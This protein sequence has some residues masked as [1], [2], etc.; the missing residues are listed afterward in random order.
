MKITVHRKGM[1]AAAQLAL[2]SA[3]DGKIKPILACAK[4]TA[5]PEGICLIEA[6]DTEVGVT[7][8]VRGVKVEQSGEMLLP[9]ALLASILREANEDELTLE[10]C[11]R[12][13]VIEGTTSRFELPPGNVQDFPASPEFDHGPHH[14]LTAGELKEMIRRINFAT[15][16]I[17]HV[18]MGPTVRGVLFDLTEDRTSLITSD[19]HVAAIAEGKGRAVDGHATKRDAVVPKKTVRILEKSLVDPE[20]LVQVAFRKDAFYFTSPQLTVTSRLLNGVF[21]DV[22]K[23]L[24]TFKGES[25]TVSAGALL[26]AVRRARLT[27]DEET[28]AVHLTSANGLIIIEAAGARGKSKSQVVVAGDA[29]VE[30][31]LDAGNLCDILAAIPPD[32]DVTIEDNGR[33]ILVL[34]GERAV[35]FQAALAGV[36]KS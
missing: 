6:T 22:R 27:N 36:V 18:K 31:K 33:G 30:V 26:G 16:D 8:E 13:V 15:S 2:A 32:V 17:D 12:V 34:E 23:L 1:L 28:K 9:I 14:E 11:G 10:L 19:G 24:K 4:V 25:L 7:A 29:K 3:G 5:L 21:P 35:Y 20:A